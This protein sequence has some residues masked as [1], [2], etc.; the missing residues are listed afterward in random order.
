MSD[1]K[2]EGPSEQGGVDAE[3]GSRPETAQS[4]AATTPA[5]EVSTDT[6]QQAEAASEQKS[7][8]P[9]RKGSAEQKVSGE[10][11]DQES[12][13]SKGATDGEERKPS[14]QTEDEEAIAEVKRKLA[15]PDTLPDGA[16]ALFI[17]GTSQTIYKC[18]IDEDVSETS[19]IVMLPKETIMADF[20]KRAAVCDFQA[21]KEQIIVSSHHVH[22]TIFTETVH[23]R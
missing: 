3:N 19:P 11:G 18:T 14:E 13:D 5:P 16:K 7:S 21:F 23:V 20:K 10:S 4:A 1:P 12:S 17:T 15:L 8:T 6:G 9:S 2:G 22:T